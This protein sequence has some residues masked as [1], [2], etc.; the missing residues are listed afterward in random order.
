MSPS[1][2]ESSTASAPFERIESASEPT[3]G[4]ESSD[5]LA[6]IA[7]AVLEDH[8]KLDATVARLRKLCAVLAHNQAAAESPPAALIGEFEAQLIPHFLAEQAEEFF[9]TLVTDKP[10]LLEQVQHLQAE[11][12]E[13]AEALGKL[14]EFAET[15]P[16]GPDLAL[17]LTRFLDQ[18]DAHEH[19]ENALMQEFLLLDDAARHRRPMK[20]E[21][22]MKRDVSACSPSDTL[23]RVAELMAEH[24][25]SLVVVLDELRHLLGMITDRDLWMGA[26]RQK[27]PLKEIVAS[28]AMSHGLV[29]CSPS[30][31]VSAVERRMHRS[32][33]TRCTA[34]VDA[35]GEFVGLVTLARI[36]ALRDL[37]R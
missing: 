31:E 18:F 34:V 13:M 25:C 2:T 36:A 5:Q 27:A 14:L 32:A 6:V 23:E 8:E 21:E 1:N 29:T 37:S 19:A 15:G 33:E 12:A 4:R 35:R 26:Y 17:R 11:H 9:G 24:G 7:E 16:P 30:D 3:G 22:I 28:T 20:V 10:R